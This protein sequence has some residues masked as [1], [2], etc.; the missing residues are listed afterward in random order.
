MVVCVQAVCD[1]HKRFIFV[2]MDMP[3]STHDSRAFSFS[4]LLALVDEG[5]VAS[6]FYLFGDAAYRG[7]VV[8]GLCTCLYSIRQILTPFVGNV[9]AEESVF[10]LYHS[11]LRM[12]IECSFGK[13][14]CM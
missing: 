12:V 4:A 10:S 13:M 14:M 3:G 7:I 5:L 11:S 9:T 8:Y 6:D 1:A 2:A